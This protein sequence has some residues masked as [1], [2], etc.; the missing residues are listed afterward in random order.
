MSNWLP[1]VSVIVPNYNH[2]Q[3]LHQRL[4][5]ILNQ[6]FSDFELILLDDCSTDNSNEIIESYAQK[7]SRIAAYYNNENS[8][9]P[10][11]QWKKG[12]DLAKG[13]FI[14]IAESDDYADVR[15]LEKLLTSLNQNPKAGVAYCQSNFVNIAGEIIGNHIENLSVLHPTLWQSDF[16]IQ[17]KEVLA[18]YMVVLNIIPN[19]SAVVFHK[20]LVK[21]INW[22]K[23]FEFKLAGD[24]FFWMNLLLKTELCFAKESLNFF[25]M[26]GNTVRMS[27]LHTISYLNEIKVIVKSINN[28]VSLPLSSKKLAVRQWFRY[29]KNA[30]RNRDKFS[31]SFYLRSLMIFC[32]ML[33]IYLNS[34]KKLALIF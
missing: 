6:T 27:N 17:G 33:T 20:E 10:F 28:S 25:R 5:S 32:S 29:F 4:N 12:I 1:K 15:L 19:A 13:E 2:A 21:N 24:R 23:L 30:R 26:D 9:S 22:D 3:F 16:C 31:V 18:K 11:K 8:G 7:D 34:K 14:W